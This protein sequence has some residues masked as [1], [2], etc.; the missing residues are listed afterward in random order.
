MSGAM[1]GNKV[2]PP[3][4]IP[5]GRLNPQVRATK[6]AFGILTRL[7]TCLVISLHAHCTLNFLSTAQHAAEGLICGP[8]FCTYCEH[9]AMRSVRLPPH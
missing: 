6:T 2:L 9:C 3:Q 7:A 8:D 5:G 1:H 4:C